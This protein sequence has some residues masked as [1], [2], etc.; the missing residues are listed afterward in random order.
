[1][2]WYVTAFLKLVNPFIDPVTKSKIKYN[3]PLT[4]HVPAAQL[5]ATSGGKVDF[6]YDHSIYW[7]AL[8]NLTEIR[9]QQRRERWQKGGKLIG[10]SEIY[11]WGGEEGSVGAGV[12][13][14]ATAAAPAASV[15]PA[16]PA[17]PAAPVEGVSG[18]APVETKTDDALVDGVNK[19]DVKDTEPAKSTA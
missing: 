19:L 2:P 5:M 11:L 14:D 16:A 18:A 4:D 13:Q 8:E 10:E 1:V 17:A 12:A 6:K 15:A 3:E 7:P 9:R